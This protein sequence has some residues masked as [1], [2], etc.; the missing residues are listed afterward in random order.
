MIKN[1]IGN[2]VIGYNK[3]WKDS[4]SLGKKTNQKFVQIPYLN[5]LNYLKYKCQLSG[6]NL[7]ETEESYTSK[8]DALA[9]E[10]I[11]KHENYSGKR[12]KR[13]LFQSGIK[14][15]NKCRC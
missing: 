8:C 2:I 10:K 14:K 7:I 4:I 11:G 9:F 12:I 5:F 15:I 3:N 6:I 13:G 1:K